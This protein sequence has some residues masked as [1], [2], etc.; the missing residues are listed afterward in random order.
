VPPP[1]PAAA[2]VSG[3]SAPA[4]QLNFAAADPRAAIMAAGATAIRQLD[5]R[6]VWPYYEQSCL[7][8]TRQPNGRARMVR[9]IPIDAKVRDVAPT[10]LQRPLKAR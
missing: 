8:D 10:P 2:A 6:E 4:R 1:A 7:H 3:Q 9:L 5:C